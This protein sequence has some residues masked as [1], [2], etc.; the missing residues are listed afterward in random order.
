MFMFHKESVSAPRSH[1]QSIKASTSTSVKFV[2]DVNSGMVLGTM[3]PTN[4]LPAPVTSAALQT[5]CTRSSSPMVKNKKGGTT[6]FTSKL[7]KVCRI[8]L[9]DISFIYLTQFS[10][11][12]IRYRQTLLSRRSY[13]F[14]L[15][16]VEIQEIMW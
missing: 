14:H 9:R 12:T 1:M 15:Q 3:L 6:Q 2:M 5:P 7:I 11:I 13:K 4:L 16:I 8:I 10:L